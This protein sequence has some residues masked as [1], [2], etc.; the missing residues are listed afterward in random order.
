[1][2]HEHEFVRENALPE[3]EYENAVVHAGA[4]AENVRVME[5]ER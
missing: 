2:K 4:G 1:M 5:L 3:E